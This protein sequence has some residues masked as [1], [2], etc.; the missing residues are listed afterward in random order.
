M[1]GDKSEPVGVTLASILRCWFVLHLSPLSHH[2]PVPVSRLTLILSNFHL[3]FLLS[4]SLPHRPLSLPLSPTSPFY[5]FLRRSELTNCTMYP[6]FA[7]PSITVSFLFSF[8]DFSFFFSWGVKRR[9]LRV[10]THAYV[11]LYIYIYISVRSISTRADP[12]K[13]E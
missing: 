5:S 11:S 12:L 7:H 6:S 8:F 1:E 13:S 2:A 4:Q 9:F 10:L 3:F